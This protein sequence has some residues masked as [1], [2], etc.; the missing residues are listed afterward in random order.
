MFSLSESFVV[1]VVSRTV[2]ALFGIDGWGKS[3]SWEVVAL[4][5]KSSL[6]GSAEEDFRSLDELT[7]GVALTLAVLCGAEAEGA[8]PLAA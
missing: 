6:A 5:V 7:D 8:S 2:W 4:D 3:T 1:D